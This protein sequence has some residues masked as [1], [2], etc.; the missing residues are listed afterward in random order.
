MSTLQSW[1]QVYEAFRAEEPAADATSRVHRPDERLESLRTQLMFPPAVKKRLLIGTKGT[2]KT[3]ELYALLAALPVGRVGVYVDVAEHVRNKVG[4]ESTINRMAPWEVLLL[5]GLAVWRAGKELDF[6]HERDLQPLAAAAAALQGADGGRATVD[7]AKLARSMTVGLATAAAAAGA[8][9]GLAIAGAAAAGLT[10]LGDVAGAGA[11]T[12]PLGRRDKPVTDLDQRAKQLLDA[13]NQLVRRP[14]E[15]AWSFVLVMDG[16][17]RITDPAAIDRMF[18]ES[19]LL[20]RLDVFTIATGPLELRRRGRFNQLSLWEAAV[21]AELPVFDHANPMN[22]AADLSFFEALWALRTK[23]VDVALA[24]DALALL[25]WAS[26]GRVRE[27]VRLIQNLA[28]EVGVA[29]RRAA[30][31]EDARAIVDREQVEFA[32]GLDRGDI[33]VLQAILETGELPEEPVRADGTSIVDDLLTRHWILPYR[34]GDEW[35]HPHPLLLRKLKLT[36]ASTGS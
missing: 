17:D 6:F 19:N 10:F 13:V 31:L 29:G 27:F 18:I 16:L 24:P 28:I 14:R 7:A 8:L 2:G 26:G 12:I 15:Q 33:R 21:L 11:W 30:T 22:P 3:T 35:F 36:P 20:G 1:T 32:V 9:P 5:A 34:N 25:A 23:G 4:D